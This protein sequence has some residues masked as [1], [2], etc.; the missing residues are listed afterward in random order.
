MS[1]AFARDGWYDSGVGTDC[2]TACEQ[3]GL[4]CT[5]EET[6]AHASE[7]DSCQKMLDVYNRI[8]LAGDYR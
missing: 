5:E 6:A 1:G 3:K 4:E 8:N 7:L 2:A